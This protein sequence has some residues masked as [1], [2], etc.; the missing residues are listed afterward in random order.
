MVDCMG[1]STSIE[2]LS[3]GYSKDG[4]RTQSNGFQG[5]TFATELRSVQICEQLALQKRLISSIFTIDL[6]FNELDGHHW[7]AVPPL[8][9]SPDKFP[10]A[11]S[12]KLELIRECIHEPA[13]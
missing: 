2:V 8:F 7:D 5:S 1:F 3:I 11:L 9:H 12:P 13:E 10:G 6:W 4:S